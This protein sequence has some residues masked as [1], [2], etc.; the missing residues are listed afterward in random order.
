MKLQRHNI[1]RNTVGEL[2]SL[3]GAQISPGEA[4][5]PTMAKFGAIGAGLGAFAEATQDVVQAELQ[6]QVTNDKIQNAI[7]D[8]NYNLMAKE[9]TQQ[10]KERAEALDPS[11]T[12]KLYA[13]D[14]EKLG[15]ARI[16][17]AQKLI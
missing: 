8:G 15:Q 14:M 9:T 12:P 4:A 13:E 5:A 7:D 3:R 1:P 2:Q 6:T 17:A 16:E 10:H 11:W